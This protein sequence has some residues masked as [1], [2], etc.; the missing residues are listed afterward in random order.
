MNKKVFVVFLVLVAVAF[1]CAINVG[2]LLDV[3][4]SIINAALTVNG[5]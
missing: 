1:Y 2:E 4:N 3:S 5:L